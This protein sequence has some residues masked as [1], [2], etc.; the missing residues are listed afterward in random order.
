MINP[1]RHLARALA[2][3]VAIRVKRDL[4]ESQA[5]QSAAIM[6]QL[7]RLQCQ[8]VFV[9]ALRE[10]RATLPFRDALD[11]VSVERLAT[12]VRRLVRE[13]CGLSGAPGKSLDE[14]FVEFEFLRLNH[15]LL[16]PVFHQLRSRRVLFV[17][18]AYYN[19]WYLSRR[20][21]RRG[22]TADLLNWDT[23]SATQIYYHG[24]DERFTGVAE[25]E[26]A[27]NLEFYLSSIY[28][29][30]LFHFTNPH[31]I[32]FGFLLQSLCEQRFGR[33]S[34]IH[35]LKA[36]SKKIIY[37]NGGCLDGVSQSSFA[38]WGPE[39]VCNI[40]R[41]KDEPAV[42]SDQRNL[43]WGAFRNEVADFQCLL[44]GNRA[45]FNIDPRVH[46]VPEFYCLDPEVWHPDL[47]VP[48]EHRLPPGEPG[49]VRLYHAVGHKADRTFAGG[50]NIKS[51]HIYEPLIAKLKAERVPV[52]LIAPV[53]VP[54][55]EVRFLQVQS[56]II[57]DMLTFGWFGANTREAMMLGKPVICFLRPEWL[58]SVRQ[59][60]PEY[61]D[62]L[63]IVSATPENVEAVLRDLIADPE[64]RAAIGSRSRAFA[65]KWHSAD[66]AAIR[67]DSIYTRLLEGDMQRR[68][69]QSKPGLG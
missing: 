33:H 8:Q 59:E 15:D 38:K 60:I 12:D 28:R 64:K 27:L 30:D 24:E 10:F 7:R 13:G 67:F 61:V 62:E 32:C 29:Y 43:E 1:L 35:L 34:E 41:W 19:A 42:C 52:E 49:L 36:L 31:A 44:G 16:R 57:L 23:N 39:P 5:E 63:P 51:S 22:W 37:S 9:E 6:T 47:E 25:D 48:P 58:E 3:M 46:E 26:A 69:P 65:L 40:C 18:Q 45:D 56:D 50:V 17:G 11:P 55:L 2:E 53:N 14:G 66:V 54:N 20:L 21:R 68:G 4:G